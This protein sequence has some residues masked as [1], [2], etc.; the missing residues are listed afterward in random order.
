MVIE[1][2]DVLTKERFKCMI[3]YI[4]FCYFNNFIGQR[5]YNKYEFESDSKNVI[6]R[7]VL[8]IIDCDIIQDY[9]SK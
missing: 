9:L 8:C 1:I 2:V 5:T 4:V 6:T 3:D 7:L